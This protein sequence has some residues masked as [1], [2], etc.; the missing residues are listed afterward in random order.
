MVSD[1]LIRRVSE[2]LQPEQGRSYL[3]KQGE[4]GSFNSFR[5]GHITSHQYIGKD[6]TGMYQYSYQVH[7][8]PNTG[9]V[10]TDYCSKV[11][12]K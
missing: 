7:F 12:I 2:I 10:T 9:N 1:Y 11:R 6:K 3:G 4:K 5:R 8:D